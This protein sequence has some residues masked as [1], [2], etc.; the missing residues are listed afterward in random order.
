[1]FERLI[2]NAHEWEKLKKEQQEEILQAEKEERERL[3]QLDKLRISFFEKVEKYIEEQ[4]LKELTPP[5]KDETLYID[6]FGFTFDSQGFLNHSVIVH[7]QD[8]GKTLNFDYKNVSYELVLHEGVNRLA[9]LHGTKI[10][11]SEPLTVILVHH[12]NEIL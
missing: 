9:V 3:L 8:V 11:A 2:G 10:K 6:T 5:I 4:Q 1:M 12:A 7:K